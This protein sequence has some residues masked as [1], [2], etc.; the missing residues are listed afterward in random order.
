MQQIQ[1]TLPIGSS[2]SGSSRDRY[3]VEAILGKGGF[4]TIYLVRDQRVRQN[5]YALKEV[6]QPNKRELEHL[7][8][9]CEILSH[10][11][12]PSLP[13]LHRV[14]EDTKNNRVYILMDYI[15]GPN[16]EQLRQQYFENRI[17]LPRM[18]GIMA[19]ITEAISFLHH[20]N[21]PIVHRDI[22]PSNIIVP[23]SNEKAVLVDF[24]IAK[25]YEPDATTTAIRHCSP[26]Y[27]APEQ[28]GIGTTPQTDIYGL[29]ATIYTLLTGRVPVDAL[30]RMVELS[31]KD[32]DP[33]VPMDKI[34]P[35]LPG[36]ITATVHRAMSVR[37]NARFASVEEFWQA[38]SAGTEWSQSNGASPPSPAAPVR[39]DTLAEPA[40][41]LK[42]PAS[43][44][45]PRDPSASRAKRRNV[46]LALALI[47]LALLVGLG[48]ATIY[49]SSAFH[50]PLPMA[51][52]T[53]ASPS[54]RLSP[55]S[56][57]PG[58]TVYPPLS[59]GYN[60]T[61]NDLV[62]KST[63]DMTLTNIQQQGKKI[64]GNFV[65]LGLTGKFVGTIDATGDMQFQV[66]IY[67]GNEI[68]SF[69]GNV[70]LGASIVGSYRILNQSGEFTGEYGLWSIS[71]G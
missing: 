62:S 18:L 43:T 70:K 4:G 11:E 16:L 61:I 54:P 42:Q 23:T 41:S 67:N 68:I 24:G 32:S 69:E 12:H 45:I 53:Q 40:Q 21:P 50:H 64:S 58:A 51:G 10:I 49:W 34:V 56:P 5:L 28:Y 59:Q 71:P 17:A 33:L 9:E 8:F 2:I 19:P 27:G 6:T 37:R 63:T 55:T 46:I 52:K 22:K 31:E 25:V 15:E 13:R 36:N 3:V 57:Q 20:Q 38:L 66:P 7:S 47:L 48:A 1:D 26:G 30:Q 60:G 29:G 39:L 65:G 14:F 35:A 44:Q